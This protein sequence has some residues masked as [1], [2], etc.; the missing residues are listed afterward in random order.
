[1]STLFLAV[2]PVCGILGVTHPKHPHIDALQYHDSTGRR[3]PPKPNRNKWAEQGEMAKAEGRQRRRESKASQ[4]ASSCHQICYFLPS[5]SPIALFMP[6]NPEAKGECTNPRDI[7]APLRPLVLQTQ[8]P[9]HR[10]TVLV[11]DIQ[12]PM[13]TSP[14]RRQEPEGPA[15]SPE[16]CRET[17]V[18]LAWITLALVSFSKPE[19]TSL[20]PP[21]TAHILP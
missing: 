13:S 6:L 2:C 21:S 3:H 8:T 5:A 16:L 1:M 15:G 17:P 12:S 10:L 9:P 4:P 14:R 7:P 11:T 19:H 18:T 20:L